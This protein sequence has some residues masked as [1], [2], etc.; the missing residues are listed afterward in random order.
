MV[1]GRNSVPHPHDA[2]SLRGQ[3]RGASATALRV[4]HALGP[5]SFPG[6]QCPL[7]P[8]STSGANPAP[9]TK[10]Q[11]SGPCSSWPGSPRG[12][13]ELRTTP[14]L[15]PQGLETHL[16]LT[17]SQ[18]SLAPG[19]RPPPQLPKQRFLGDLFLTISSVFIC[20]SKESGLEFYRP[21]GWEGLTPLSLWLEDACASSPLG[22]RPPR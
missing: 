13:K 22:P 19:R 20:V 17:A 2:S 21:Q 15:P 8:S 11:E 1:C 7:A 14:S 6:R 16:L 3:P 10:S 4:S 18:V 9:W 12:P 5:H